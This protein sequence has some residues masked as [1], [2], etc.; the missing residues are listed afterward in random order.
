MEALN[1]L[2]F[3]FQ[4]LNEE[5]FSN[6]TKENPSLKDSTE[7]LATYLLTVALDPT[8]HCS[9]NGS[10]ATVDAYQMI[11]ALSNVTGKQD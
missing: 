9:V 7:H 8:Y 2:H 6:F 10:V 5:R 4:C 1:S 3:L 11:E